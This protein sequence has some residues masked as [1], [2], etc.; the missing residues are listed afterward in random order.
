MTER[1]KE[2]KH[3]SRNLPVKETKPR[4]FDEADSGI[5]ESGVEMERV[6]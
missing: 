1:I 4:L 3:A 2:K 6:G 5:P